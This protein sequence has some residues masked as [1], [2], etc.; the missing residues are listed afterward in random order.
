M[1][2]SSHESQYTNSC[3]QGQN[4]PSYKTQFLFLEEERNLISV[5]LEFVLHFSDSDSLSLSYVW[6]F[7]TLWTVAHQ[8]PLSMVFFRRGY[9]SGLP[10]PS[11]GDLPYLGTEPSFPMSLAL[12][13]DSLPAEP[14]GK[15][16][17]FA[18]SFFKATVT[19]VKVICKI[20]NNP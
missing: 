9:W 10:F 7:A 18:A 20:F 11:P 15:P 3:V 17:T 16:C 14:L 6:L 8:L 1:G 12:Q 13:A 2:H 5:R 19:H 4:T